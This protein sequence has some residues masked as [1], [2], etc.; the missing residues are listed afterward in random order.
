[1][2]ISGEIPHVITSE[3]SRPDAVL[4]S[5]SFWGGARCPYAPVTSPNSPVDVPEDFG[6]R[7]AVSGGEIRWPLSILSQCVLGCPVSQPRLHRTFWQ[8]CPVPNKQEVSRSTGL[9]AACM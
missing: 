8:E 3:G 2:F 5:A 9:P 1:M 4:T 6:R 7:R